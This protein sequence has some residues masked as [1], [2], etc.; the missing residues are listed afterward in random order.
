MH[1]IITNKKEG[2]PMKK[3]IQYSMV[4]FSLFLTTNLF[5]QTA[6]LG[7][8]LLDADSTAVATG[9]ITATN[10]MVY[11][12]L[13]IKSYVGNS[14]TIG[15]ACMIQAGTVGWSAREAGPILTRFVEVTVS[16]IAGNNLH[17]DSVAFWMA[18]SGTHG[19]MHGA[20]YWDDNTANFS[21][22][23]LLDYDSLTTPV[24]PST[25]QG[26]ADI[27]GDEPA[28]G[29]PHDTTITVN[30]DIQN[31][32]L[33]VLR[34][35]PWYN[36]S[37]ASTTKYFVLKDIRIYGKTTTGTAVEEQTLPT[38]FSLDQNYPNPFNP[39]TNIQFAI[40]E[41]GNYSLR[42]YNLLGQ[43]VAALVNGGLTAGIHNVTFDASKLTSGMYIYKLTGSNV[44]I[45]KKMLLMK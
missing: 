41:A 16:P 4:V 25:R 12:T 5:A 27:R 7:Q 2:E 1:K 38:K 32:K 3:F 22:N 39:T 9:E 14:A 31:G 10:L 20:V 21:Q 11:G 8:W 23:N 24:A 42:V 19:K 26:L 34:F 36:A 13:N 35:Y 15:N 18:C 28:S 37:S 17:V 40:P 6:A 33:F 29:L 43:E 44:N 30:T 45:S